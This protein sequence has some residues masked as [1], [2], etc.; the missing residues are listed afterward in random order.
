[1]SINW[2]ASELKIKLTPIGKPIGRSAKVTSV[3]RDYG[4]VKLRTLQTIASMLDG[5]P[6][7]ID[8][9]RDG[10]VLQTVPIAGWRSASM[11]DYIQYVTPFLESGM[12]LANTQLVCYGASRAKW[13]LQISEAE[14]AN[15]VID[16]MSDKGLAGDGRK[17]DTEIV[18][19]N[20]LRTEF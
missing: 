5:D 3:F 11:N 12:S 7:Y 14:M 19:A 8:A 13:L 9:M 10:K 15:D 4:E 6:I 16:N 1:M 18:E 17:R 2:N 20:G